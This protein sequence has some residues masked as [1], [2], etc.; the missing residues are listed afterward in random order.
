[1]KPQNYLQTQPY[2]RQQAYSSSRF[3]FFQAE[4]GIRDKL[5]TGVQTCALPISHGQRARPARRVR[6]RD[7]RPGLGRPRARAGAGE[8]HGQRGRESQVARRAGERRSLPAESAG[9][10]AL[11]PG[12]PRAALRARPRPRARAADRP[13]AAGPQ[14][15]R[16]LIS[17]VALVAKPAG[18]TSHDVVEQVR[19]A[20]GTDRVGHLGTLDPFAVGL[21]VILAGRA[22]RLAS[23]AAA[24]TKS[25]EGVIRLGVVTTTDDATGEPLATCDAWR[26]LDGGRIAEALAR[27]RGAYAQRPPAYSAGKIAGERAYRRAR[28]G[29]AVAPAPRPVQVSELE[30]T[31]LAL[32]DVRFRATV[33][34]GTYLRSLARD[35]GEALGC[36]AHLA[37]L[38]RTRVGPFPLADAVAPEAVTLAALRDPAAL[39]ADLPRQELDETGRAAVIHGRPVMAGEGGRGRGGPF[40]H[41]ELAG[42]GRGRRGGL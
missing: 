3:F 40:S 35:V 8:R 37:A 26:G 21:L 29:E 38:T 36:G 15:G 25:Y 13:H 14:G 24:W 2:G 5:V 4:D 9:P 41:R 11:A 31:G 34:A 30:L 18:P 28:R 19:R 32:P 27:F 23:C 39:V 22:T 10:G 16:G 17:G 42:G 7:G 33:S 12:D 1:M 6:H 20:L